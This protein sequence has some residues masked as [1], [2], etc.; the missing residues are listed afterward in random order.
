MNKVSYFSLEEKR[1]VVLRTLELLKNMFTL[2][3]KNTE[4][5]VNGIIPRELE[6]MKDYQ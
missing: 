5:Y 6:F 3:A 4:R 1:P 2:S